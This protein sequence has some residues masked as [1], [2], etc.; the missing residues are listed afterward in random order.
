MLVVI[1]YATFA[2]CARRN[3]LRMQFI[4]AK[5]TNYLAIYFNWKYNNL[6]KKFGI[7]LFWKADCIA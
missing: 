5:G 4:I 2:Y 7:R 1:P 6:F 3:K